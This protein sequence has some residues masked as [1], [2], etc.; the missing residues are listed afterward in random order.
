MKLYV[1]SHP[2][3][4]VY[5]FLNNAGYGAKKHLEALKKYG[6]ILD[7][8]CLNYSPVKAINKVNKNKK[9]KILI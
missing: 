9:S 3:Y 2:Q 1:K 4:E 6:K 8:N 7:F 5:D